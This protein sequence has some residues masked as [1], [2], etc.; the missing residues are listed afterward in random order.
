MVHGV[1]A[2]EACEPLRLDELGDRRT[3][4][5]TTP[6]ELRREPRRLTSEVPVRIGRS[7]PMPLVEGR[8]LTRQ[9][10]ANPKRFF[11]SLSYGAGMRSSSATLV[12][13]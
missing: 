13:G 12:H 11:D 1:R 3:T 8:H 6:G 2:A 7:L 4:P 5:R 10:S 9:E